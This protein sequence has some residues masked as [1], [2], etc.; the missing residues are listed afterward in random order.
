MATDAIIENTPHENQ[1]GNNP[2]QTEASNT[3]NPLVYEGKG[4][5]VFQLWLMNFLLKII[6]LGIYSFWGK[7]RLRKYIY[8]SFSLGGDRFEYT[9]T[10]GELFK[11]FLKVLPILV[12]LLGPIAIWGEQNPAVL[13]L[14]FPLFYL[15]GVAIYGAMRYR[16]SRTRWR[17]IRARLGGS[18]FK[19]ANISA[20]RFFLNIITLGF[21]IPYSDIARTKY[22]F[23]NIY[24]GNVQ[25]EYNGHAKNIYGAYIKSLFMMFGVMIIPAVLFSIP[26]IMEAINTAASQPVDY[27]SG[28]QKTFGEIANNVNQ[29]MSMLPGLVA[30]VSYMLGII[31]AI[32]LIPVARSMYT[33]ALMRE[34]MR[35]L[36]V[37][38]LRFK[39]KVTT[40]SLL[41]HQLGNVLLLIF[42]LGLATPFVINRKAKFMAVNTVIYGDLDTSQ[43]MQGKDE[44][45]TSGEGLEDALDIDAGFI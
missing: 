28:E 12:I 24:F 29:S 14:Y 38:D 6:T 26:I 3:E 27:S 43:V 15:F 32:A 41:K 17:G 23:G 20:S 4:G 31:L 34:S 8:G 16:F 40:W 36:V 9:G 19:Y 2:V 35:G 33:A 37:G 45:I 18:A 1:T 21:A 11:G 25:A 30:A 13:L 39:S 42:T 7:T 22:M 44:G 5:Q 10:G